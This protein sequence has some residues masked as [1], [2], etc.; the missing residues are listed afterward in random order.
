MLTA[1]TIA[2]KTPSSDLLSISGNKTEV[3][4]LAKLAGLYRGGGRGGEWVSLPDPGLIAEPKRHPGT[5]RRMG[6]PGDADAK[7]CRSSNAP[8]RLGPS[9]AA[10]EAEVACL[11]RCIVGSGGCC[12]VGSE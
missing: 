12:G 9:R 11:P 1:T 5:D 6:E 4:K 2:R 8:P 3:L 7:R 10:P